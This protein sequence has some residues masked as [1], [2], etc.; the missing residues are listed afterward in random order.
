MSQIKH[1]DAITK[2]TLLLDNGYSA[3]YVY[4]KLL[5]EGFSEDEAKSVL[6]SLTDKTF[7]KP[8]LVSADSSDTVARE[9]APIETTGLFQARNLVIAAFLLMLIGL[10]LYFLLPDFRI[11]AYIVLVAGPIMILLAA[12]RTSS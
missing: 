2:A 3:S 7:V 12:M 11:V 10:A 5:K 4:E 1:Q 9:E 8:G 6:E